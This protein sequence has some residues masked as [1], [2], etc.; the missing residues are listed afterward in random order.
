MTTVARLPGPPPGPPEHGIPQPR[1]IDAEQQVLGAMLQSPRAIDAV[2]PI[3]N[4]TDFYQPRHES[5]FDAAAELHLTGQPVDPITVAD[6]LAAAKELDRIGGPAYLY[7]LLTECITP[8]NADYHA[9]IVAARSAERSA[10]TTALNLVTSIGNRGDTPLTELLDHARA[11]LEKVPAGSRND[12]HTWEPIDLGALI[13]A[14]DMADVKATVG[15]RRDGQCLLYPAAVHSVSGEPGSGKTWFAQ[16]IAA[17]ELEQGRPVLY[18]DFEDRARTIIG[19]LRTLGVDDHTIRTQL[20]YIRPDAAMT[21]AIRDNLTHAAAGVQYAVIDGI[22]EAMTMHGLSLM[23]NEDVAR[24]LHLL[25]R[26]LADLGASVLQIDHVVKN[27]EQRGRYAIGGQHKLAG[28]D[29]AAYKILVT[30]PFGKGAYGR[31]KLVVDKDRHGDVGTTG[32]TAADLHI[33]ARTDQI[34]GWLDDPTEDH[35]PDGS[36]RPT[37]YMERIARIIEA[38]PGVSTNTICAGVRG[39]REHLMHALSQLI[40]EGHVRVEAGAR[41]ASN[42][43]LIKPFAEAENDAF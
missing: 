15:P 3:I 30:K 31:A 32:S 25:P 10:I 6:H 5:I 23:D 20:R 21:P 13:D 14:G 34:A 33:D 24:W 40:T 1:D 12:T 38:S 36:W 39:K 37:G 43:Y 22:T 7:E 8:T 2:I 35:A 4:G 41:G 16:V 11:E 17:H 27:S 42:H 18:I 29:G 9:D 26:R 28:I 19:R